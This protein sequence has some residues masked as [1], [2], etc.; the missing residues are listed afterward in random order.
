[1]DR[2][3]RESAPPGSRAQSKR[4]PVASPAPE[5]KTMLL[6]LR[7]PFRFQV[8]GFRFQKS[9]TSASPELTPDTWNLAKP[10]LPQLLVAVHHYTR[11]AP[12]PVAID[13]CRTKYRL[14]P[15]H[16]R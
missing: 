11:A 6:S 16:L 15:E 9:Q 5:R 4:A 13:R 7:S 12:Q 14:V 2:R 1:M 3:A 8:S 10:L